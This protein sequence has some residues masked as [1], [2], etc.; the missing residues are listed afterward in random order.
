MVEL[1]HAAV[2]LLPLPVEA[3]QQVGPLAAPPLLPMLQL[4][5]ELQRGAVTV[6]QQAQMLLALLAQAPLGIAQLAARLQL[7]REE[8]P[9]TLG[10]SVSTCNRLITQ[11]PAGIGP[12]EM[13]SN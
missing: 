9:F 10:R 11:I 4:P 12:T 7:L 6:G 1:L 13:L 5:A 8:N 3:F 2:P